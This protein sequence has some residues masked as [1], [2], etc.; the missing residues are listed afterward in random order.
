MLTCCLSLKTE[1][2]SLVEVTLDLPD[3]VLRITCNLVFDENYDNHYDYN[4]DG[5]GACHDDHDDDDDD[6]DDDDNMHSVDA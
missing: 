2:L 1:A 6:G 5:D 3:I 4:K